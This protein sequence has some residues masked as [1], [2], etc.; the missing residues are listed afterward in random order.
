M[1]FGEALRELKNGRKLA[2]KGWNGYR[3]GMYIYLVD[4]QDV[5]VYKW[6]ER[7]PA[8]ATTITERMNNVVKILPHIDMVTA[9]GERV[10]GWL[11]SQTDMLSDDWEVIC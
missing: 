8:Q 3:K 9:T 10:I 7:T 2:R 4:G 5:P 11:A 6:I 1:D